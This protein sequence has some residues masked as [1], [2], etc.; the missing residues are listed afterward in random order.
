[1]QRIPVAICNLVNDGSG[2]YKDYSFSFSKDLQCILSSCSSPGLEQKG[3]FF[4]SVFL[5]T[6]LY[7]EKMGAQQAADNKFISSQ[8]L[9][10]TQ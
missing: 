6:F 10:N 8:W 9:L 7:S 1:M 4:C 2:N 3:R 5:L